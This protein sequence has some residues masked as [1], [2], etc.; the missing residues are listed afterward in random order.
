MKF[1][2]NYM[3]ICKCNQRVTIMNKLWQCQIP[4]NFFFFL[5]II[6]PFY[7]IKRNFKYGLNGQNGVVVRLQF[8]DKKVSV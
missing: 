4:V 6:F 5:K 3:L 8:V 2:K 1:T 7:K